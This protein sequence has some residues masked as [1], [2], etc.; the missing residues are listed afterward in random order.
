MEVVAH[1]KGADQQLLI[2]ASVS[3]AIQTMDASF[4]KEKQ[5]K[6]RSGAIVGVT[7]SSASIAALAVSAVLS[8]GA[9]A[10]LLVLTVVNSRG[11]K[12]SFKRLSERRFAKKSKSY[13]EELNFQRQ[14][15]QQLSCDIA[16]R[17]ASEIAASPLRTEISSRLPELK[18][19]FDQAASKNIQ[20]KEPSVRFEQSSKSGKKPAL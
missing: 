7:L 17:N 12:S 13:I 5:A 2:L 19:I 20:G 11:N 1:T 16:T 3:D 18:K 4:Q 6:G 15:V 14:A 8:H 9:T 10:P